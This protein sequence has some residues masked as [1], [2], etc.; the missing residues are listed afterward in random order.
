MLVMEARRRLNLMPLLGKHDM[1]VHDRTCITR[2]AYD[3]RQ[4]GHVRAS[5]KPSFGQLSVTPC[6]YLGV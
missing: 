5:A 6:H 4:C 3:E 1:D 2:R